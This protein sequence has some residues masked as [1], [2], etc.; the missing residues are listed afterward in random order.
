MKKSNT[1]DQTV[2]RRTGPE[3]MIV[4]INHR[5]KIRNLVVSVPCL[6]CR[7]ARKF[8]TIPRRGT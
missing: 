1:Y 3:I 5:T 6:T 7:I 8:T 4:I 2:E